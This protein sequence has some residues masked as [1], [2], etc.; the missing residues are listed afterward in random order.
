MLLTRLAAERAMNRPK[1]ACTR[2]QRPAM[3]SVRLT[4]TYEYPLADVVENKYL[5]R[6]LP[7]E[8]D[9]SNNRGGRGL[10][11]IVNLSGGKKNCQ[12]LRPFFIGTGFIDKFLI[13]RP[14]V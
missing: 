8:L 14:T 10:Q 13:P 11:Q 7:A 4:L 2:R 5:R 3:S 6:G 9:T 12:R 1:T